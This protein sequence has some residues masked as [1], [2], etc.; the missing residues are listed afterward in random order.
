MGMIAHFIDE[1]TWVLYGKVEWTRLLAVDYYPDHRL[2]AQLLPL[3]LGRKL[4]NAEW[5]TDMAQRFSRGA[6]LRG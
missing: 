5:K 2:Q 3:A 4:V 6:G 1:Q